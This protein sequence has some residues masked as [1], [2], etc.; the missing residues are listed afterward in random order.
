[1]DSQ[2]NKNTREMSR[3]IDLDIY[4]AVESSHPYYT[5]MIDEILLYIEKYHH[6]TQKTL[7]ILELGAGTGLFTQHLTDLPYLNVDALEIDSNAIH[8]LEKNW[9]YLQENY[10]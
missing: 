8:I 7:N 10:M 4:H 2:I 6:Q 5:E 9:I 3:Y 1:M